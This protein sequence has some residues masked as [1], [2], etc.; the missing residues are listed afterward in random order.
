MEGTGVVRTDEKNGGGRGGG[1]T[2]GGL[3][4]MR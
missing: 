3:M 2:S 4:S 1:I